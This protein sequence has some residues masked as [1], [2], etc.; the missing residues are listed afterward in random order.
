MKR[1]W[2]QFR[3]S[4]AMPGLKRI[5]MSHG[6]PIEQD[7]AGVLPRLAGTLGGR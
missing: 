3:A 7:V 2:P 1:R 4:A 6:D 5:L